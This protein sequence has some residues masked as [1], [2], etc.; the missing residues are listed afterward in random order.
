MKKKFKRKTYKGMFRLI[1]LGTIILI[2]SLTFFLIVKFNRGINKTVEDLSEIE[3]KRLTYD[4][5]NDK[6]TN[7]ILN[8]DNL[9]DIL[10]IYKNDK[11][12]ILY[13]D[14]DLDKA[15]KV[16]DKVTNVLSDT[17]KNIADSDISIA[18]LDKDLSHS[19]NG[20]VLNIPIGSLFK[21]TYFYNLGPKIPIKI[22]FLGTILTNLETK[23]T[24]YGLNNALVELFVYIKFEN[25]IIS[26]FKRK[27][28]DMEYDTI[29]ASM[30]IEGEVPSF[31]NGVIEKE[32]GL[33]T[34][35]E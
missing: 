17:Y 8:K 30:M 34:K 12:E 18:Y 13:V 2:I 19:F 10:L 27:K 7:N 20:F 14:F 32:S 28:I 6:I 11:K 9:K 31:Y 3:I 1:I 22:N 25:E 4:L 15:Y 33:I 26:P 21:S 24:N 16:L 35:S 5:I 23:V 29:I